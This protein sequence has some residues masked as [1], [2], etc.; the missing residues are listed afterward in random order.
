MSAFVDVHQQT[1]H[2]HNNLKHFKITKIIRRFEKKIAGKVVNTERNIEIWKE[3]CIHAL[4]HDWR[5]TEKGKEVKF[6]KDELRKSLNDPIYGDELIKF[7]VTQSKKN[8][9]FVGT[10]LYFFHI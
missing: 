2:V 7:I 4:V 5:V 6:S 9:N 1:Q 10:L 3:I 8:D